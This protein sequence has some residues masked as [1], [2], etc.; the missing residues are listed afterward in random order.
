MCIRDRNHND[1]YALFSSQLMIK[2]LRYQLLCIL[3]LQM[4]ALVSQLLTRPKAA[5]PARYSRDWGRPT[6]VLFSE[7]TN[8]LFKKIFLFLTVL[9]SL[10]AFYDFYQILRYRVNVNYTEMSL[11]GAA[12][13][14]FNVNSIFS[15][16][17]FL[18]LVL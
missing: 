3:L 11:E 1:V 17:L 12:V 7:E 9:T 18:L 2:G 4:G 15:F 10:M 8:V 14:T 5:D 16:F 13:T 6:R